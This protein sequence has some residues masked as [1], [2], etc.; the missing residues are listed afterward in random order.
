MLKHT[1]NLLLRIEL[2][3]NSCNNIEDYIKHI[4]KSFISGQNTVQFKSKLDNL[5]FDFVPLFILITITS[6]R[7]IKSRVSHKINLFQ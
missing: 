3:I 6:F 5:T 2:N 1:Y 4:A 7:L